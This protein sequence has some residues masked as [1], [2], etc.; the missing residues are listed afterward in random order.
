[1][2]G[3]AQGSVCNK[4]RVNVIVV[5]Q[6]VV[7]NQLKDYHLNLLFVL[8]SLSFIVSFRSLLSCPAHNFTVLVQSHHPRIVVCAMFAILIAALMS[9]SRFMILQVIHICP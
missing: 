6:T 8:V 3:L 7:L 2:P 9:G 4:F 5:L 1:M